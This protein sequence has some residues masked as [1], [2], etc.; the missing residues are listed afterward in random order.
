MVQHITDSILME[1]ENKSILLAYLSVGI[2]IL[3]AVRFVWVY[4]QYSREKRAS[5]RLQRFKTS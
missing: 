5:E 1:K 3:I 4:F 2:F